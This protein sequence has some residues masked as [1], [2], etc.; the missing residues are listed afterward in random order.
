M[1]FVLPR[2]SGYF[3]RCHV[4]FV[5]LNCS[6]STRSLLNFVIFFANVTLPTTYPER[7][8]LKTGK[9]QNCSRDFNNNQ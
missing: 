3:M 5:Q 8:N 4:S 6:K 9:K 1:L 2:N 7:M